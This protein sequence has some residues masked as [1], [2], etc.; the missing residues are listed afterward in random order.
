MLDRDPRM[1][2]SATT[3]VIAGTG[4]GRM[5]PPLRERCVVDHRLIRPARRRVRLRSDHPCRACR[6]ASAQQTATKGRYQPMAFRGRSARAGSYAQARYRRGLRT[7]RSRTRL[8]LTVGFGPFIV[9]GLVGLIVEGHRA[10]WAAGALFGAG[11]AAIIAMRETPPVYV[12]NWRTGA[13]GE[14]KTGKVLRSLQQPPWLIVHDVACARGNYDHVV[15][16][17]AGVFLLET[18]N[19]N[20]VVHM[21]DG[22][23]HLRRRSD[24]EADQACRWIR[25]SALAGAASLSSEIQ[26]RTG[27]RLWVRAVVVLWSGF[28]EGL[29]EEERC[30]FVHGSRLCDWIAGQPIPAH[31][32]AIDDFAAAVEAMATESRVA[33]ALA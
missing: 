24:P 18:K 7:W 32:A 20:G 21:R 12:E 13:Q 2:V 28:D 11:A 17:P 26:R 15:V 30:T 19:L 23:P 1:I 14:R 10:A 29:V 27:C 8:I 31:P 16:G 4:R 6:R 22:E 33:E 25:V 5:R 9:V 3:A